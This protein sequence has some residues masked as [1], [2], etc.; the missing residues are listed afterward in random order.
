[1]SL[2]RYTQPKR[3]LSCYVPKKNVLMQTN[4]IQSTLPKLIIPN[5][6]GKYKKEL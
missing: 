6:L 4:R 3:V 5:K 2:Q 1:M